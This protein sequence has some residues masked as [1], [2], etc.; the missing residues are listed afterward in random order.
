[1]NIVFADTETT[2]LLK[3]SPARLA[4]QPSIIELYACKVDENFNM[5]GEFSTF[6]RVDQELEPIITKITGI[7]DEMLMDQPYF[8][9]IY[10]GFAKFMTGTDMLVA[11]NVSF[12]AGMFRVDLERI[13]MLL[14]FPWPRHQLCTVEQ[15][16]SIK[17][18]RL[19]LDELHEIAVGRPMENAHRARDDVHAMIR[20]FIW[21][22]QQGLV[23]LEDYG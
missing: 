11:H 4:T 7:T 22:V 5:L 21:L 1:M 18:R 10:P 19:K 2:G 16:M 23:N 14:Q 20:S 15:S 12:D 9:E 8:A 6:I 17:G 3:P 13:G